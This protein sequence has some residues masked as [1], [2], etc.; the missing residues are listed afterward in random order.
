MDLFPSDLSLFELLMLILSCFL[1]GI[2]SSSV[3]TGGGLII[4]AAMGQFLPVNVLIPLHALTQGGAG[5]LRSFLFRTHFLKS[6]YFLFTLGSLFGF[7]LAS[8]FLITLSDFIL[9]LILGIGIIALNII[10]KF[11]IDYM[12][13]Y[14]I[15]SFGV[16]TG[17]LTMF[18]GVMGPL[19]AIFLASYLKER[20][21]IIGTIAW[22]IC[23]QNLIKVGLFSNLG[24]DYLPWINL[25]ILLVIAAFIGTYI[26]KSVL[27][28][29]NNVIFKKLLNYVILFLGFKLI[30]EALLSKY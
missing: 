9:K 3:G 16:L 15:V 20:H 26:G 17:F 1:G 5:L 11:K 24:F 29:M 28:R 19:L 2:I 4:I 10:P 7:Y 30:I 14:K 18:M 25:S 6:F 23:T 13:S 22:C 8:E 12:S 21:Q 27:S